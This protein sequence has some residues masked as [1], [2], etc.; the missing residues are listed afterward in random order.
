[1]NERKFLV[2]ATSVMYMV[3]IHHSKC[4]YSYF[5]SMIRRLALIH[6]L[7]ERILCNGDNNVSFAVIESR[8]LLTEHWKGQKALKIHVRLRLSSNFSCLCS[9]KSLTAPETYI[10]KHK[11]LRLISHRSSGADVSEKVRR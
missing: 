4:F 10:S 11:Q 7:I 9:Q 2:K 1:M 3:C 8:S 5:Q 6:H